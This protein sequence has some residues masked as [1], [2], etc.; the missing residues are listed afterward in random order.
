MTSSAMELGVYR[1]VET[2]FRKWDHHRLVEEGKITP[3]CSRDLVYDTIRRAPRS[4]NSPLQWDQPG[5]KPRFLQLKKA[6]R[7]VG[8]S[9]HWTL[10]YIQ[11]LV[12]KTTQNRKSN[13]DI[14]RPLRT[15]KSSGL[16]WRLLEWGKVLSHRW[17]AFKR[18]PLGGGFSIN[19]LTWMKKDRT[20]LYIQNFQS[21][22]LLCTRR[23]RKEEI[24]SNQRDASK[25]FG[26][27]D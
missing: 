3:K 19:Y 13:I 11:N 20:L 21:S 7:S 6:I 1:H 15:R 5:R 17:P 16:C 26:L 23:V 18:A 8:K 4:Q 14:Q 12:K 10:D 24:L 27:L 25:E 2:I 22:P 9:S